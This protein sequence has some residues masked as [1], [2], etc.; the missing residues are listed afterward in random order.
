VKHDQV[1]CHGLSSRMESGEIDARAHF[2]PR[3]V[4]SAPGDLG[5]AGRLSSLCQPRDSMPRNVADVELRGQVAL[6][7]EAETG[8]ARDGQAITLEPSIGNRSLEMKIVRE[9]DRDDQE[10]FIDATACRHPPKRRRSMDR[11]WRRPS[12]FFVETAGTVPASKISPFVFR[13]ISGGGGGSRTRVASK[14]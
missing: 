13:K 5:P 9:Q 3:L 4:P 2:A 7:V 14:G 12:R 11:L 10:D 6:E 1:L 8:L